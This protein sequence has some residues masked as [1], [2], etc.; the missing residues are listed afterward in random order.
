MFFAGFSRFLLTGFRKLILNCTWLL[1]RI[2]MECLSLCCQNCPQRATF[3][4]Q[5]ILFTDRV[6]VEFDDTAHNSALACS[7]SW[8]KAKTVLMLTVEGISLLTSP[9]F[10]SNLSLST[11]GIIL[12]SMVELVVHFC[13]RMIS[14]LHQLGLLSKHC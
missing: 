13:V 4:D 2:L 3:V 9:T 8:A 1:S 12:Q 10:S 5:F 14:C 11:H 7:M 6:H